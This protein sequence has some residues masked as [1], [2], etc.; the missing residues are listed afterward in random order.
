MAVSAPIA[1]ALTDAEPVDLASSRTY[2]VRTGD[3]LW[4]IAESIAPHRDPRQVIYEIE[5]RDPG[6]SKPLT[7]GQVLSVP[8]IG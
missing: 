5:Q 6:A 8:A 7:P 3:T 1:R 4:S 2:V